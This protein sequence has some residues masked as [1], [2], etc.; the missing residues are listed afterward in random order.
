[1]QIHKSFIVVGLLIALAL[2]LGIMAN[3]EEV[4]IRPEFVNS[5]QH[6]QMI[7]HQKQQ[8]FAGGQFVSNLDTAGE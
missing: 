1:M 6:A 5:T 2:F 4:N 7:E 8:T 3:A